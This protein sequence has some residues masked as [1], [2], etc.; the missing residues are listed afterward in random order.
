VLAGAS[1]RVV[2]VRAF[3]LEEIVDVGAHLAGEPADGVEAMHIDAPALRVVEVVPKLV[4]N[5]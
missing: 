3:Q 5:Q 1:P 2:G 4:M